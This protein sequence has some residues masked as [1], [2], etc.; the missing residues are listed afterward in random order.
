ML[1]KKI[2]KMESSGIRKV[3]EMA[4]KNK[5]MFVNLSI[6]QPHFKASKKLKDSAKEAV[7]GDANGYLQTK[8]ILELRQE[9]ALNLRKTRKIKVDPERIIVTNGVSGAIFLLFSSIFDPGDE[10]ILPDPYFVLY[11]EIL[12]FLEV[13]IKILNT[14]P[15]FRIDPRKLSE[16]ISPKTK[17][18]IIN[19]P[20]NPTG[21]VY[22]RKEIERIVDVVKREKI[23]IISDEI[24]S[25]FDYEKKF[26]SPASIYEK[27]I[28]LDGFSKSHSVPGW[29]I[30]YTYGPEEVIE[31]MNKLQQYTFICAPS[32]AQVAMLGN[33]A[34][35][36]KKEIEA[37]KKKRDFVY[38]NLKDLY[39]FKKPD[40]AFYAFLKIPTGAKNFQEELIRQEILVVSGDVFSK[41]KNYFRISFAVSDEDL[42]KGVEILR[43]IALKVYS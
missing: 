17:A 13:K 12:H 35:F 16:L 39:E 25:N 7:F 31:A 28:L 37:Y 4:A 2:Q 26:F 38:Q 40:G 19:S 21:V 14:Y 1:S 18:I 42:K 29:R 27:T 30:G 23:W 10:V 11:K 32:F 6:G 22:D 15:D 41:K 36:P 24:Y 43:K 33:V 3:F 9:I 8:G 5:G 20:N 34:L